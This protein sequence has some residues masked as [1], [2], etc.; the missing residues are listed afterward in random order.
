MT[1]TALTKQKELYIIFEAI[2]KIIHYKLH[3]IKISSLWGVALNLKEDGKEEFVR[4]CKEKI[5]WLYEDVHRLIYKI[6]IHVEMSILFFVP[7]CHESKEWFFEVDL[8]LN[9][10]DNEQW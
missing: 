10:K 2:H 1:S 3:M 9:R 5:E 6:I 7:A 8:K 4:I